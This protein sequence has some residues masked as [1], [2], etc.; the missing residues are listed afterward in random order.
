MFI[1]KCKSSIQCIEVVLNPSQSLTRH[2]ALV[3]EMLL[4]LNAHSCLLY[5][6]KEE[7]ILEFSYFRF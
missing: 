6:H 4:L 2:I 1:A 3:L 5:N 7:Y